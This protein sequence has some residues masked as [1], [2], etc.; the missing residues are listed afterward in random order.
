[1]S[2][3]GRASAHPVH[4]GEQGTNRAVAS[5][6]V[7]GPQPRQREVDIHPVEVPVGGDEGRRP[8]NGEVRSERDRR[9]GH[10]GQGPPHHSTRGLH[11][12]APGQQLATNR[13][14]P[15]T[16][17]DRDRPAKQPATWQS[18]RAVPGWQPAELAP[19]VQGR[20]RPHADD[21]RN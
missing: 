5:L 19:A 11:T 12:T 10:R 3:F 9:R 6:R 13:C 20:E 7:L 14:N 18:R 21:Q 15:R 16:C 8:V 2:V 17:G 4:A 1:M